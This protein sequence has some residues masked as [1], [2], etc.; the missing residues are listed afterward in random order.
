M[1]KRGRHNNRAKIDNEFWNILENW[2]NKFPSHL[3]HYSSNKTNKK[4]FDD[5]SLN[6]S[7]L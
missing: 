7:K 3:S 1:D 5:T 4:F 6:I 2:I